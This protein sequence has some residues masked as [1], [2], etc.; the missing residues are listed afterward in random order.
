[1]DQQLW[2]VIWSGPLWRGTKLNQV[3]SFNHLE[4]AKFDLK[5]DQ[6]VLLSL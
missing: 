5:Q 1:M 2:L 3:L 4:L 6:S